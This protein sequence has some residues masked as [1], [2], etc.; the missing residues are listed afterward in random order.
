MFSANQKW[1]LI[2]GQH[3]VHVQAKLAQLLQSDR[4]FL[5]PQTTLWLQSLQG[6]L[7]AKAAKPNHFFIHPN[8][9]PTR[10][11]IQLLI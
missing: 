9:V 6:G 3:F 5:R 7:G 8:K 1:N 11:G 4:A 2:Y 10:G